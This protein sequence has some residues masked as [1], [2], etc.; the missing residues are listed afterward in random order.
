MSAHR[1]PRG[2]VI[3]RAVSLVLARCGFGS[4]AS[5]VGSTVFWRQRLFKSDLRFEMSPLF[6]SEFFPE[7]RRA[8]GVGATASWAQRLFESGFRF[9]TSPLFDPNSFPEGSRASGVSVTASWA[10]RL[11]ESGLR[12]K[13][14]LCLPKS[15]KNGRG[16][17]GDGATDSSEERLSRS[18]LKLLM[19]RFREATSLCGRLCS[20]SGRAR[21]SSMLLQWKVF[22]FK[23]CRSVLE[24]R[25]Y[26]L[27]WVPFIRQWRTLYLRMKR[28][29]TM[30]PRRYST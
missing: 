7:G 21:E 13:T 18:G 8:S 22:N 12:F 28:L 15:S 10:Q 5:E 29:W 9:E 17:V 23:R 14:S 2:G 19:S 26:Q 30:I 20:G 24:D 27:G 6:V 3:S 1:L 4:G 25:T 16:R 11:F